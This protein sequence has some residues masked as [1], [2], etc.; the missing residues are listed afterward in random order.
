M[1]HLV[2]FTVGI[3][4]TLFVSSPVPDV[5]PVIKAI[6]IVCASLVL[7]DVFGVF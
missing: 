7:N 1:V 5:S 6:E 2:G 4:R 3:E